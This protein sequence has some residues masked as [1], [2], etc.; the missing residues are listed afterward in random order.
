VST[1][2]KELVFLYHFHSRGLRNIQIIID[3]W[4]DTTKSLGREISGPKGKLMYARS[5]SEAWISIWGSGDS[6]G[7]LREKWIQIRVRNCR[8]SKIFVNEGKKQ[9]FFCE[10]VKILFRESLNAPD[11]GRS[12]GREE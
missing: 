1:F 6:F 7:D 10:T 5:A 8:V 2:G 4:V 11:I 9:R 3:E 12:I